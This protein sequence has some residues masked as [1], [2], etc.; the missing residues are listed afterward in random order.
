MLGTVVPDQ[1]A[2]QIRALPPAARARTGYCDG[3]AMDQAGTL[4][5]T[6][7][8][9]N[10]IVAID[11]DGRR[12]TLVHDPAGTRIDFPTNLAWGGPDR[13]DLLGVSRGSGMIVCARMS[14]PGL[15]AAN[16]LR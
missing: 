10:R 8:F 5:V 15:P 4:F 12:S 6:L 16:W 14:V 7:P 9:A 3:L 1:T 2:P 11:R 13:R